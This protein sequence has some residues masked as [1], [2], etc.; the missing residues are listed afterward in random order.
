LHALQHAQGEERDAL[1]KILPGLFRS[2]N[3]SQ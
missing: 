2:N 1:M 3:S